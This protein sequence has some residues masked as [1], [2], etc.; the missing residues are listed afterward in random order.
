MDA[1]RVIIS[2]VI[3][4]F[5]SYLVFDLFINGFNW[6][7]FLACVAGYLLV[8]YTW[9]KKQTGDSPWYDVLELIIELPFRAFSSLLRGLGKLFRSGDG[10][11]DIDL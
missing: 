3:F 1:F 11:F 10:D 4:T 8:H 9:P 2:I 7:V 5:S 6:F